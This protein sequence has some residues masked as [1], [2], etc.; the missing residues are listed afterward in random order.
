MSFLR[1][2]LDYATNNEAPE[3]FHVWSAYACLSAAVG[4]R[5]WLPFGDHAIFPNIYVMLVGNAG[6]GKSYALQK[7]KRLLA[8]LE[9]VPI[10]RSIETPEGLW[11][12]MGGDPSA[13]PP[14]P[15]PV[16]YVTRWPDGQLREVHPMT[17]IANEFVN[18]ISLNQQAWTNALNDIYDEDRYEY[19]T[20]NKGEDILIGPY[21]VL[22]GALTTDISIDLQK[23]KI[24]ASGFAR[25]TI[26][27]YGER[28]WNDPH[29]FPAYSQANE[30]SRKAAIAHAK[31]LSKLN[32]AFR[33][34][35]A[36]VQWWIKWYTAHSAL[37]PK[38]TMQVQSWFTSKPVQ[39]QKIAMLTA[40]S[41]QHD[42]VLDVP[43]FECA[44]AYLEIMEKNLYKIFGGVGRNELAAVAMSIYSYIENQDLPV[45][46]SKLKTIFW[47]S[48]KPPTDFEDCLAYLIAE[49]KVQES[50][51]QVGNRV[52][53]I[54]AVPKVMSA[55]Q[56]RV[57]SSDATQSG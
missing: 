9:N 27:Q 46:R 48:C 3:M 54:I 52:D 26:F 34:T 13:N 7:A 29:P 56:A 15:S 50:I 33:L 21:I 28:K 53:Q 38:Q 25:R 40:L 30:E 39:L 4:R 36:A 18:F 23:A 22:L 1:N 11:R 5:V 10:S 55:F 14:V 45:S 12:F 35:D 16:A 24:I 43:Y 42:L 2:Y 37:V 57:K 32:G 51:L 17:I 6:N 19:R 31:S 20:K 49:G 8:E 47:A 44:L 41:E